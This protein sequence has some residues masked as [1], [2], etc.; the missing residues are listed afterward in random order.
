MRIEH[1]RH[2]ID[3]AATAAA[4]M[5]GEDVTYEEQPWV[6]T[7]QFDLN[8]QVVGQGVGDSEVLRGAPRAEGFVAFQLAADGGLIGAILVNQGRHRRPLGKLVAQ[9]VVVPR[10][11]LTDPDTPIPLLKGTPTP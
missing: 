6:W 11:A 10:E 5:L 7:D 2:A 9:R 8:V 4:A 1:W 3:H